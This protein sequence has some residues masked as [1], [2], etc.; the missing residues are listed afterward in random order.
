MSLT[1][2]PRSNPDEGSQIKFTVDSLAYDNSGPSSSD[3]NQQYSFTEF[4]GRAIY[5]AST[6]SWTFAQ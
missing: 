4:A 2:Y 3:S 1:V 5:D 6:Q